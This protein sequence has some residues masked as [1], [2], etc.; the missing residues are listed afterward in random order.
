MAVRYSQ[1]AYES[2]ARRLN[3]QREADSSARHSGPSTT[4]DRDSGHGKRSSQDGYYTYG[5]YEPSDPR[6]QGRGNG[7]VQ[8]ALMTEMQQ[9]HG[10]RAVQRFIQRAATGSATPAVDDDLG[11]RI[12]SR[13]GG[14]SNLDPGVKGQVEK[15]MGADLSGVRVHTDGEA[16]QMARSVDAVAFTSGNDIFFRE[17]AYDPG[18]QEGTRLIAH[19]ATHTVQQS[20]GPVAGTPA[21]GGVAISDPS[22]SYEQAAS[23]TAEQVVSGVQEEESGGA[24]PPQQQEQSGQQAQRSVQRA[25][26]MKTSGSRLTSSRQMGVRAANAGKKDLGPMEEWATKKIQELSPPFRKY[27]EATVDALADNVDA[28]PEAMAVLAGG[29]MQTYVQWLWDKSKDKAEWVGGLVARILSMLA[30]SELLEFLDILMKKAKPLES[31]EQRAGQNV[32]GPNPFP[33]NEVMVAS[34]RVVGA[35]AKAKEEQSFITPHMLNLT[36][37]ERTQLPDVVYQMVFVYQQQK[38]G[39]QYVGEPLEDQAKDGQ[40]GG[41]E[42]LKADEETGKHFRDYTDSQQAQIASDYYRIIMRGGVATEFEPFIEELRK[43]D[44]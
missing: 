32:L 44:L 10:N 13:A 17:G 27:G 40:Y 30:G 9:T 1:E 3:V 41:P 33:W 38:V 28:L 23:Q 7:P 20:R 37:D 36:E 11:A 35:I 26:N 25:R 2:S 5:H 31:N 12:E 15:G 24:R 42:M 18:S 19:E 8:I 6:F 39:T 29:D 21:G 34:G 43:G 16:D 4:A 22:D 14:G